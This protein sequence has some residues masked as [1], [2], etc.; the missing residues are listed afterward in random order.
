MQRLLCFVVRYTI[1]HPYYD[2]EDILLDTSCQQ[3]HVLEMISKNI[4]SRTI[5]QCRRFIS[6]IISEVH[7]RTNQHLV[8]WAV[9][10]LE[11]HQGDSEVQKL[12]LEFKKFKDTKSRYMT[13]IGELDDLLKNGEIF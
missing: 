8:A 2:I 4:G 9:Q 1:D 5:K 11:K 7:R 3:Y 12:V 13:I 6:T 10:K